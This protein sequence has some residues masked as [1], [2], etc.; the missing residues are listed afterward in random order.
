MPPDHTWHFLSFPPFIVI[1]KITPWPTFNQPASNTSVAPEPLSV[2][3]AIYRDWW[4]LLIPEGRDINSSRDKLDSFLITSLNKS[5]L[6]A[7]HPLS[8]F[9]LNPYNTILFSS[10]MVY[11]LVTYVIVKLSKLR[12]QNN[13]FIE[14]ARLQNRTW[15]FHLQIGSSPKRP[16]S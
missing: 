5:F 13:S 15:D 3:N 12:N 7:I 14:P 8:L 6:L 1:V 10:S 16:F 4:W 2:R 11:Y 9:L